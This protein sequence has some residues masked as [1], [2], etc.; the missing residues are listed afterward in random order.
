MVFL[1]DTALR[2]PITARSRVSD[3]EYIPEHIDL[4]MV[5]PP[6][7][8]ALLCSM[9]PSLAAPLLG[10]HMYGWARC[11]M[12]M[13]LPY[14][15]DIKFFDDDVEFV[16]HRRRY[17]PR[18]RKIVEEGSFFDGETLEHA[19]QV[20]GSRRNEFVDDPKDKGVSY[21]VME[22]KRVNNKFVFRGENWVWG[23]LSDFS[24]NAMVAMVCYA[25]FPAM[26][27]F[28]ADVALVLQRRM[29][30]TQVRHPVFNFFMTINEYNRAKHRVVT[31]KV[32]S[33][34]RPWNYKL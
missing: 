20:A 9:L 33:G 6:V 34:A 21:F 12:S 13:A 17:D 16:V 22:R 4:T 10:L 14:R 24:R 3:P 25:F 5:W 31:T 29:A 1:I 30:F 27:R 19:L 32:P 2:D 23:V 28:H 26:R 8:G 15:T 18:T 11:G 7:R